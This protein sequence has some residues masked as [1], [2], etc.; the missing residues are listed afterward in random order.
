MPRRH[1]PDPERSVLALPLLAL[2]AVAPPVNAQTTLPLNIEN[3]WF[4]VEVSVGGV[5]GRF[6]L[7]TGAAITAVSERGVERFELTPGDPTEIQGASGAQRVVRTVL[8]ELEWGPRRLV[9]APALVVPD[10]TLTPGGAS[11]TGST[12]YDGILGVEVFSAWDVVLDPLRGRIVLMDRGDVLPSELEVRLGP[13]LKAERPLG[14]LSIP[15]EVGG[16]SMPAIVD[17]GSRRMILSAEGARAAGLESA[18]ASNGG[19][20]LGLGDQRVDLVDA[21][22]GVRMGE[23]A[24]PPVAGQVG[25]LPVFG[26]LGFEGPVL[27]IGTPLL[28]RCVTLIR[29]SDQ[30]VR[31]C[32]V[33]GS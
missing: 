11:G 4:V 3:D 26:V 2:L 33:P 16:I 28:K 22:L 32:R 21:D 23:A 25:D 29:W 31:T 24:F 9:N 14:L 12:P 7:D 6:V 27:L 1:Q 18:V 19:Q 30:T 15:V 5:P 20:S 13:P 17:S 10:R 8:P